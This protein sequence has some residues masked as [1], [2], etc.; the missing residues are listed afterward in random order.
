M[1]PLPC[2]GAVSSGECFDP[3][4]TMTGSN[5]MGIVGGVMGAEESVGEESSVSVDVSEASES[6]R[7]IDERVGRW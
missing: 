6:R 5:S 1:T 4:R 3:E 2:D 7:D